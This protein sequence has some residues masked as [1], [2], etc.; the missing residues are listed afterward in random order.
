MILVSVKNNMLVLECVAGIASSVIHAL[1]PFHPSIEKGATGNCI[2]TLNLDY[3]NEINKAL[4][5]FSK[6]I[7]I[8]KSFSDW[9][10]ENIGKK[11]ILIRCGVTFSVIY[12]SPDFDIPHKDIEDVAKYFF[13]P[14]VNQKAYKDKKW[15]GYIHLYKRLQR[16]FPTGLLDKVLSVLDKQNIPYKV[17]YTYEQRPPRQFDWEPRNLFTLSEDQVESIDAAMKAG[18]C[19]VKAATGFGKIAL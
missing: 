11:P 8:D 10:L 9:K 7:K 14:A 1:T 4:A 3:I 2:I 16:R 5:P 12:K 6:A 13:K 19:V 17:E 15:D 18:R